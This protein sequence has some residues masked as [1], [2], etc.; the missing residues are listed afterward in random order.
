L[1]AAKNKDTKILAEA[2]AL[3]AETEANK[4]STRQMLKALREENAPPEDIDAL[5]RAFDKMEFQFTN[6]ARSTLTRAI[7]V[8]RREENR[9]IKR[10]IYVRK[11]RDGWKVVD[12]GDSRSEIIGIKQPSNS[13]TNASTTGR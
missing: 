10:I 8:A 1:S 5:A 7:S 4:E 13:G 6:P 2:T 12:I 9:L 11:E 3:R